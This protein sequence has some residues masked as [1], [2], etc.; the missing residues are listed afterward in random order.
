M[1]IKKINKNPL[2]KIMIKN[3]IK[4]QIKNHLKKL[5]NLIINKYN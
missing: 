1:Q 3:K 4:N 5:N 2:Y